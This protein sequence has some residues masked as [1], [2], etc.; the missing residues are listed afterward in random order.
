MVIYSSETG[1]KLTSYVDL[2]YILCPGITVVIV[3]RYYRQSLNCPK[4]EITG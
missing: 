4:S 2:L 1:R 3:F